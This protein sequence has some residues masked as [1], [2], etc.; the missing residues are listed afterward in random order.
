ML[1]L[2]LALGLGLGIAAITLLLG[3]TDALV[4]SAVSVDRTTIDVAVAWTTVRVMVVVEASDIVVSCAETD[5]ARMMASAA[6]A[7]T[8]RMLV[9]LWRM[10][11][12]FCKQRWIQRE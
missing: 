3:L 2:A 8:K 9:R 11:V 7:G 12:F 6:M 10:E 1:A 5:G 4:D